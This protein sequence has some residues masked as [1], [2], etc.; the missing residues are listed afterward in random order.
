MQ[1]TDIT[2]HIRTANFDLDGSE[3]SLLI[4]HNLFDQ[5]LIAITEPAA[6]AVYRNGLPVTA[7]HAV[8]RLFVHTAPNVPQGDIERGQRPAL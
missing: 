1:A 4:V 6:A 7:K 2:F 8:D 3:A 5:L